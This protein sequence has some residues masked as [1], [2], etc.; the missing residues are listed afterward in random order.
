MIRKDGNLKQC[1][2]GPLASGAAAVVLF[3][4]AEGNTVGGTKWARLGHGSQAGCR[5]CRQQ[6]RGQGQRRTRP[7]W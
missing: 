7:G 5:R 4:K 3:L 1:R 2:L 6:S